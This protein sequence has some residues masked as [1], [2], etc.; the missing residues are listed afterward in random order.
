MLD[1]RAVP[2]LDRD[3]HAEDRADEQKRPQPPDRRLQDE[4]L[5]VA[6]ADGLADELQDD[7]R[8]HERHLPVEEP[9]ADQPPRGPMQLREEQRCE[10]PDL[11]L[12]TDLAQPAARKATAD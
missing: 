1:A 4:E 12:R 6:V 9:L 10:T 11:F 8:R 7:W 3:G 5:C 2:D